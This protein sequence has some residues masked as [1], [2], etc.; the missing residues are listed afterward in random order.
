MNELEM[1]YLEK[2]F[3]NGYDWQLS[4]NEYVR[5]ISIICWCSIFSRFTCS[6]VRFKQIEICFMFWYVFEFRTTWRHLRAQTSEE[7]SKNLA[8]ERKQMEI[9]SPKVPPCRKRICL[10]VGKYNHCNRKPTSPNVVRSHPTNFPKR[11][12]IRSV[13]II[14]NILTP[15]LPFVYPLTLMI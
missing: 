3:E 13:A 1:M 4:Q 8:D 7:H 15:H 5:R 9:Q 10:G 6:L 11:I 14:L 2:I 12:P